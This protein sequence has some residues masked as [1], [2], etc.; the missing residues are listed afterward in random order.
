MPLLAHSLSP[1]CLSR[2][3]SPWFGE[4]GRWGRRKVCW[5]LSGNSFYCGQGKLSA[6]CIK[7]FDPRTIQR[8]SSHLNPII[9]IPAF[10]VLFQQL[11]QTAALCSLNPPRHQ[12]KV[13]NNTIII[14][15]PL[16]NSA[17]RTFE[18]L[19]IA[20]NSSL[21][22]HC[23]E[24]NKQVSFLLSSSVVL[25]RQMEAGRSAVPQQRPPVKT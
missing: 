18:S 23:A 16:I 15:K 25:A 7:G 24:R 1:E 5:A 19:H 8:A 9:N 10:P 3:T 4:G 2:R 20:H 12:N 22:T 13:K 21:W 17:S 6:S 11:Q 14:I